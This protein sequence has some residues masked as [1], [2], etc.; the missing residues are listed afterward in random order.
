MLKLKNKE[1]EH[2]RFTSIYKNCKLKRVDL[3]YQPMRKVHTSP[4]LPALVTR[5]PFHIKDGLNKI[6]VVGQY[7]RTSMHRLCRR[8]LGWWDWLKDLLCHFMLS[9]SL[10]K[11]N[12]NFIL[13]KQDIFNF[14]AEHDKLLRGALLFPYDWSKCW[15]DQDAMHLDEMGF[16][17]SRMSHGIL[18]GERQCQGWVMKLRYWCRYSSRAWLTMNTTLEQVTKLRFWINWIKFIAGALI[19]LSFSSIRQL[20]T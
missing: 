11:V 6:T 15:P 7:E 14:E 20:S 3:S 2:V 5:R 13:S 8:G 17:K 1:E 18:T 16:T 4:A 12:P 10:K 19:W 9:T